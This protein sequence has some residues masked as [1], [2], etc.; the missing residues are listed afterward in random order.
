[1]S[2]LKLLFEMP[3]TLWLAVHFKVLLITN[4]L[5]SP[6]LNIGYYVHGTPSSKG[7]GMGIML[8]IKILNV[9]KGRFEIG[10]PQT[11]G[12]SL[13]LVSLLG[14]LVQDSYFLEAM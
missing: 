11:E 8:R 10:L 1:M 9:V 12:L 7:P 6:L 4:H 14:V 5:I 3:H 2:P 13:P